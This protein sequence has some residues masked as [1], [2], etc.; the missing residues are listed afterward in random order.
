MEQQAQS[1]KHI[2]RFQSHREADFTKGETHT[3]H[4]HYRENRI[5]PS[6]PNTAACLKANI[7]TYLRRRAEEISRVHTAGKA[8]VAVGIVKIEIGSDVEAVSYLDSV[9]SR[10]LYSK[11]ALKNIITNSVFQKASV[12]YCRGARSQNARRAVGRTESLGQRVRS[13]KE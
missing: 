6:T 5:F 8:C 13:A 1:L 9:R 3:S 12:L 11:L 10:C 7:R 4:R 2:G